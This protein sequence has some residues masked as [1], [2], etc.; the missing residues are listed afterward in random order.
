MKRQFKKW[1]FRILFTGLL[2]FGL[3]TMFILSPILLYAHKTVIGNYSIYHNKP[4]NKNFLLILEQSNSIIKSSEIYDKDLKMDIC[5]KDGSKYPG[6]IEMVFG[7]DL[8]SCFYNKVV[9]TSGEPNFYNNSIK[10]DGHILNLKEMLAHA[11][12]HC[13]EFNHY[14]LWKSN[15]IGNYPKWKWEGYPEYIGRQKSYDSNL[16]EGLKTLFYNEQIK[17]TGWL[18]LTDGTEILVTYFKYRL[19]TQYCLEI[20]KLEFVKLLE[21]TTSEEIVTQEMLNW[22]NNQIK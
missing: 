12:V 13:L 11:Q 4:I 19:L 16:K 9:F 7:R 14:G 17:N 18:T 1:T 21:D 22:Y 15:P 3:L 5:L 20:K 6:L 10:F 2:I 8:M